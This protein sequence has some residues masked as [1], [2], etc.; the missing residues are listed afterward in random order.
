M[1]TTFSYDHYYLQ[2]EIEEHIKLLAEKYPQ[3]VEWEYLLETPDGHHIVA[4]TLTNKKTG[5]GSADSERGRA[6]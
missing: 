1:K 4:V 6:G 3:L 5:A 2:A